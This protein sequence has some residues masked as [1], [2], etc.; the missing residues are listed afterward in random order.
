MIDSTDSSKQTLLWKAGIKDGKGDPMDEGRS[1]QTRLDSI[2]VRRKE[3]F[4][5]TSD[6]ACPSSYQTVLKVDAGVTFGRNCMRVW[7]KPAGNS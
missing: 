2:G 6:D 4:V 3:A 5:I 1:A 7:F